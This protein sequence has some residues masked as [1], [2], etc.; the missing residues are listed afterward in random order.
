MAKENGHMVFA[1]ASVRTK[2]MRKERSEAG[3]KQ[4]RVKIYLSAI[5]GDTTNGNTTC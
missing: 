3:T 1:G 2:E 4:G 5:M